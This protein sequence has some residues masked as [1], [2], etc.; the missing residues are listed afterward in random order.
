MKKYPDKFFIE[1]VEGKATT[2]YYWINAD[3]SVR[4][5]RKQQ[6]ARDEADNVG[7]FALV[8]S[9]TSDP[10]ELRVANGHFER[11]DTSQ[12]QPDIIVD[13]ILCNST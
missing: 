2:H 3:K 7:H 1:K 9:L 13:A 12:N 6:R 11:L 10:G 5:K 4:I 8:D